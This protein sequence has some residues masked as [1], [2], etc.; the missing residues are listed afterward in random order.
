ME[1]INFNIENQ[2]EKTWA[3]GAIEGKHFK[4]KTISSHNMVG[5]YISDTTSFS[6]WECSYVRLLRY[7]DLLTSDDRRRSVSINSFYN[8]LFLKAIQYYLS[9]SEPKQSSEE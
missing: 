2:D 3:I 1:A 7:E 8:T 5:I 4:V 6:P 9:E